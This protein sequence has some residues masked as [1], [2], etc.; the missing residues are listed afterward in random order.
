MAA[1]PPAVRGTRLATRGPGYGSVAYVYQIREFEVTAGE[2][3]T[4]L[5]RLADV[6]GPPCYIG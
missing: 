3:R 4:F 2:W 5:R 1:L 6:R